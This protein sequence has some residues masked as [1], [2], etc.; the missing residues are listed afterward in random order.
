MIQKSRTDR[1]YTATSWIFAVA[2]LLLISWRVYWMNVHEI[3]A[4]AYPPLALPMAVMTFALALVVTCILMDL[5]KTHWR[6]VVTGVTFCMVLLVTAPWEML[7]S[8]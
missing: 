3:G 4:H 1:I 2:S 6:V 8:P 7:Q 5:G